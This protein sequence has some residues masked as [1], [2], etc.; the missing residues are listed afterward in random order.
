MPLRTRWLRIALAACLWLPG[1]TLA[2]T[3][4]IIDELRISLREAPCEQCAVVQQG[5]TS[6]LQLEIA[7]TRPG[8]SQVR[9]PDGK[10]GWVPSRYLTDQPIARDQVEGLR[11]QLTQL[12]EENQALR[13]RLLERDGEPLVGAIADTLSPADTPELHA[14]NQEL[15]KRNKLL[16]S[17]VEVLHARL[18]QLEGRERQR[19]F[20]YGGVLVALGA[21][22]A[23]LVP[24]LKPK[25]GGYSE[26]R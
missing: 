20:F 5:L 26:W 9:T 2:A 19:W 22:V 16:Q 23:A 13:E 6:G 12:Q 1:A 3:A 10:E 21:L 14:Q 4:Y 15:L 24:R 17:D 25:R 7:D 8:W 18:E 11:R